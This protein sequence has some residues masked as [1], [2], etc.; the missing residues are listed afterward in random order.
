MEKRTVYRLPIVISSFE[1]PRSVNCTMYTHLHVCIISTNEHVRSHIHVHDIVNIPVYDA[2]YINE[3]LRTARMTIHARR[4]FFAKDNGK[5]ADLF[6][7]S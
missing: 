7:L 1:G 4:F 3:H 2:L 6:T 5:W